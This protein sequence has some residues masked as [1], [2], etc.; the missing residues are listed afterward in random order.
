[1]SPYLKGFPSQSR[2]AKLPDDIYQIKF[3]IYLR[4]L[5]I[6]CLLSIALC[7]NDYDNLSTLMNHVK[8]LI[9]FAKSPRHY[10]VTNDMRLMLGH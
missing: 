7:L 2:D 3:E 1:M 5:Y 6:S 10:R 8:I 9:P 4:Y